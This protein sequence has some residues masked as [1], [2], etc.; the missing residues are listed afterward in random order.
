MAHPEVDLPRPEVDSEGPL[1][2]V[3]EIIATVQADGDDALRRY[4]EAFDGVTLDA[5]R[6]DP[7]DLTAAL[8]RLPADVRAALE[9]AAERIRAHHEHQLRGPVTHETNGVLIES[10]FRPVERVGCYVPGGRASYPS[11]LL[12]TAIPAT[13][14]GAKDVIVCVPPN[15]DSGQIEDVTLAA[16]AVAGVSNVYAVGGAQA[17]AAMAYGTET[18]APVDVICGPGNKYVALAQQ[19]VATHVGI[20]AA[21]AGPSEVV[22][23]ADDTVDPQLVAVDV[24][25]Q[26][27]HGPDGLAW[28]ITW[29][30]AVAHA[31]ISAVD[32]LLTTAPRADEI[33]STLRDAGYAVIVDSPEAALAVSD[34]V[35]PEHLELM[36][37]NAKELALKVNNAGAIFVGQWSPASVG[38]Y[39]AGPS[40][41]LPTYGTAR[42]ASALT[43]DDFVKHHHVITV[44]EQAYM[45]TTDT[46]QLS[47]TDAVRILATAE[48]LSEHARSITLRQQRFNTENHS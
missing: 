35:A 3:R 36:C 11:T 22:V 14:A 8:N 24:M 30:E 25:L 44:E 12:M 31:V 33:K 28:L 32:E 45:P 38:D 1:N 23:I 15:K 39:V 20:A 5:I 40:H 27:E 6:V 29:D 26:A 18:I 21:F 41:V 10:S 37:A 16:A 48:G 2:A 7:E 46:A 17:V 13:V 9:L 43:V 47:I 42:F 19:E 34:A 4:S